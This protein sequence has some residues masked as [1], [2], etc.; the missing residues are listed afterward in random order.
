MSYGTGSYGNTDSAPKPVEI[1]KEYEV[2]VTEV[3]RRGD[4][5]AR[6]QGFV[7]FVENG[8]IG[9]KVKVKINHIGDRFAKAT[10]V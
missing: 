7:L 4:G 1:D 3:S 10:V 5:V 8:K 2:D 9:D 6:I